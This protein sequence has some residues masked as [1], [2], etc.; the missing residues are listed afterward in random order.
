MWRQ[1]PPTASFQGLTLDSW[2]VNLLFLIT[3]NVIV[4]TR[5]SGCAG[6]GGDYYP[7]LSNGLPLPD[8]IYVESVPAIYRDSS[9]LL[10]EFYFHMVPS[11]GL[12]FQ[13]VPPLCSISKW[14]C[15]PY[16]LAYHDLFYP[17]STSM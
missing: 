5:Q 7:R 16:I 17:Y 13:T 12:D 14:I 10:P 6:I 11:F 4:Y 9:I 2:G 3:E 15:L 1:W 8:S